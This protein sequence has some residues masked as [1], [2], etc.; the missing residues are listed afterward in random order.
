MAQPNAHFIAEAPTKG[1]G[2]AET[3]IKGSVRPDRFTVLSDS[4]V[5][6]DLFSV[7]I[8]HVLGK[9]ARFTIARRGRESGFWEAEMGSGNRFS[10]RQEW[11]WR[12]QKHISLARERK[13]SLRLGGEEHG[14]N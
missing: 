12:V 7:H 5:H 14:G 4:A 13:S 2:Q 3:P 9:P 11:R 6:G 10:V 1:V 8:S